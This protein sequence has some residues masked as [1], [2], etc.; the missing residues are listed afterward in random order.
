MKISI[1]GCGWLGLPLA[2]SFLRD[3]HTVAGTKQRQHDAD[4]LRELGIDAHTMSL[5][6]PL[7]T[8]LTHALS[9]SDVLVLNIPS[10]RKHLDEDAYT[11]NMQHI[12]DQA[13]EHGCKHI[14]YISTTSVYGASNDGTI[15]EKERC[16]PDTGS[17]RA[18]MRIE[19]HARAVFKSQASILRLAGLVGAGRH[20]AKYLAGRTDIKGANQRINLVH[21]DD[22]IQAI[23]HIAEQS[24]WGE[25]F[26]LAAQAHP[27]KADY[28]TSAC[29]V[30][31]IE[32][33]HFANDPQPSPH[34]KAIDSSYTLSTL[35][36]TLRYPTPDSM[37][38]DFR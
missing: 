9:Q 5:D 33:P 28:Y 17:G 36:L 25:T 6:S 20:P 1:L 12:I 30:L 21:L 4:E 29:A 3:G 14:I 11:S 34:G 18:N 24:K 22:A 16:K 8:A 15:T 37:L 19:E 31:D 35:D 10:G 26:H 27:I 32:S 2:L 38:T 7:S 13:Y 23:K